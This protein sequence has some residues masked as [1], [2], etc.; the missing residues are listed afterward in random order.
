MKII[1]TKNIHLISVGPHARRSHFLFKKALG[2]NIEV[3]V[4]S[5]P[6]PNYPSKMVCLQ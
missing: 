6:D 2:P 5:L 3:G 4:T 1:V